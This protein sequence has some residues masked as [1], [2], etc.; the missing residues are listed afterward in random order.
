MKL[1]CKI[2]LCHSCCEKCLNFDNVSSVIAKY[3]QGTYKELNQAVD[4]MLCSYSGFFPNIKYIL[5]KCNKCG[6]EKLKEKLITTN[7]TKLQDTHKRFLI[8][9]WITKNKETNGVS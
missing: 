7:A 8:K 1:Q 2:P 5:H 4:S 6:T 9:E 3:L